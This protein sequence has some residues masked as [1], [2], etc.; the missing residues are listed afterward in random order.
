MADRSEVSVF[1]EKRSYR[2]RRLVDGLRLLP[3]LGAW[4]FMLPLLWS[5]GGPGAQEAKSMSA[6][7]IFVFGTWAVLIAATAGILAALAIL[8]A[9][10]SDGAREEEG[11][12]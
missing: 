10:Q 11:P 6:A 1:L 3:F 2:R 5:V 8:K 7:L 12:P 9:P 4:L